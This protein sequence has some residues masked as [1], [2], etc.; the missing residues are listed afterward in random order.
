VPSTYLFC[1]CP[2]LFV[3]QA[4]GILQCGSRRPTCTSFIYGSRMHGREC[5][6]EQVGQQHPKGIHVLGRCGGVAVLGEELSGHLWRLSAKGNPALH[7]VLCIF[8]FLTTP[9]KQ[10]LFE[11]YWSS[12]FDAQS[13]ACDGCLSSRCSN[14]W[15]QRESQIDPILANA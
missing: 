4:A 5:A 12:S 10:G 3:A 7:S 1:K 9:P 13:S 6:K 8:S 15:E 11:S 2:R 14:Q